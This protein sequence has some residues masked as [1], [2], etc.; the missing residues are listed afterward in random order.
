MVGGLA[1]LLLAERLDGPQQLELQ[2]R[3]GRA[4]L[5]LRRL[6]ATGGLDGG[7]APREAVEHGVQHFDKAELDEPALRVRL[8]LRAQQRPEEV[9]QVALQRRP[10]GRLESRE[11]ERAVRRGRLVGRGGAREERRL[12]VRHEVAQRGRHLLGR[13]QHDNVRRGGRL[14]VERVPALL[15]VRGYSVDQTLRAG[16]ELRQHVAREARGRCGEAEQR[17][18]ARQ[19]LGQLEQQPVVAARGAEVGRHALGRRRRAGDLVHLLCRLGEQHGD[20]AADKGEAT[21]AKRGEQARQLGQ[22]LQREDV[23]ADGEQL[24]RQREGDVHELLLGHELEE[25]G[26]EAAAGREALG[27]GPVADRELGEQLDDI[28]DEG[29]QLQLRLGGAAPLM[30]LRVQQPRERHLAAA[31]QE[32]GELL[33]R[34][35]DAA[36]EGRYDFARARDLSRRE[37]CAHARESVERDHEPSDRRPLVLRPCITGSD[38]GVVVEALE[39]GGG[40]RLERGRPEPRPRLARA[41]ALDERGGRCAGASWCRG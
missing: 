12:R 9:E 7:L 1:G 5:R 22:L 17:D 2:L 14:D 16:P 40:Q 24:L 33:L 38:G 25:E 21:R 3:L 23:A 26:H 8:G 11:V 15:V 41:E 18:D 29:L 19:Q 10:E 34:V 37:R 20:G 27:D 31:S 32:G 36:V 30:L 35:V 39:D 13:E 4:W 28:E 6:G